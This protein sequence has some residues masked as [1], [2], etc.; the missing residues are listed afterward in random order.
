MIIPT[1]SIMFS[2]VRSYASSASIQAGVVTQVIGAVVD[3]QVDFCKV[4]HHHLEASSPRRVYFFPSLNV[5]I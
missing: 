2:V 3:V 1:L 4:V 5:E